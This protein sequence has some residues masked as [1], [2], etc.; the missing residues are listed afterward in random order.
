MRSQLDAQWHLKRSLTIVVFRHVVRSLSRLALCQGKWQRCRTSITP[1]R[2]QVSGCGIGSIK[3]KLT[4]ESSQNGPGSWKGLALVSIKMIKVG[5]SGAYC[6]CSTR[7]LLRGRHDQ[8]RVLANQRTEFVGG[9]AIVTKVLEPVQGV[10]LL[11][12]DFLGRH[13]ADP[14]D[15]SLRVLDILADGPFPKVCD[16]CRRLSR[17]LIRAVHDDWGCWKGKM[18]A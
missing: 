5:D 13:V 8:L 17:V 6:A 16:V 3:G 4:S 1:V 14:G 11:F 7:D 10:L 9:L 2:C 18:K 15:V 12:E